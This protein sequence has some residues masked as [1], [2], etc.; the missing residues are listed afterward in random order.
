MIGKIV[1][2]ALVIILVL[3]V[4]RLAGGSADGLASL[5]ETVLTKVGEFLNAIA[6]KVAD[7]FGHFLGGGSSEE[8]AKG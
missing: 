2:I 4:W 7:F 5:F 1:K 3:A 8:P 6:T